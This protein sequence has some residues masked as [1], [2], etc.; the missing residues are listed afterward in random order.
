MSYLS[1]WEIAREL[2]DIV[3]SEVVERDLPAKM[4]R[5]TADILMEDYEVISELVDERM[6]E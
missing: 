4:L 6:Q 1:D 2:A 5:I 3:G